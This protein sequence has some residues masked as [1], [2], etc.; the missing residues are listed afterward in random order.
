MMMMMMTLWQQFRA[1]TDLTKQWLNSSLLST[2]YQTLIQLSLPLASVCSVTIFCRW[3]LY[4]I[5][6]DRETF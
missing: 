2:V 6:D 5:L 3:D 4:S 1:I